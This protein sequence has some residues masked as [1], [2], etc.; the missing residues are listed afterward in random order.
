M[1]PKQPKLEYNKSVGSSGLNNQVLVDKVQQKINSL[2]N[3][4]KDSTEGTDKLL[5]K[6]IAAA[7]DQGAADQA[8]RVEP[9]GVH[10]IDSGEVLVVGKSY[11]PNARL[12]KCDAFG[13]CN[14]LRKPGPEFLGD[15]RAG[16]R[17]V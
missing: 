12:A 9:K 2:N 14:I 6:A 16:I 1:S 13:M 11:M 5:F 10:F 17:Q 3:M 4:I 7:I 8:R 15:V